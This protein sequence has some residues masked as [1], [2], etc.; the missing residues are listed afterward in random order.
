VVKVDGILT[1]AVDALLVMSRHFLQ[2][3]A[4]VPC[5][6]AFPWKASTRFEARPPT[7][8]KL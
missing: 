4:E 3:K 5:T 8:D 1:V 6:H 7:K 2:A